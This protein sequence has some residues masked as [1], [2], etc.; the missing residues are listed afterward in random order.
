MLRYLEEERR[1]YEVLAAERLRPSD[2]S[3]PSPASTTSS[4]T[5]QEMMEFVL[6]VR[7]VCSQ[8][9]G[10]AGTI[11]RDTLREILRALDFEATDEA[12]SD[13]LSE[14]DPANSGAISTEDFIMHMQTQLRGMTSRMGSPPPSPKA[15][16]C[17]RTADM[18]TVAASHPSDPSDSGS[19]P[20]GRWSG[21]KGR[22]TPMILW[23]GFQD[24][25]DTI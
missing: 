8:I 6:D 18:A 21:R 25:A 11:T 10:F 3:P 17:L 2:I 4:A 1:R 14:I 7:R 20:S 19:V 23:W 24:L 13:L 9:V 16:Q 5:S 15:N 12:I 22:Q